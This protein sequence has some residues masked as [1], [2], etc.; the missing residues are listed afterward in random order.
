MG[1][2]HS[3]LKAG[4]TEFREIHHSVRLVESLNAS[5]VRSEL[6]LSWSLSYLLNDSVKN[7]FI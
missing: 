4:I 2:N 3:A 1:T 6:I 5:D 7:P